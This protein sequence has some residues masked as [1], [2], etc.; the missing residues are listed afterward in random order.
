MYVITGRGTNSENGIAKIRPNV[1]NYLKQNK[2]K[3]E[4]FLKYILYINLIP[5]FR[6]IEPHVGLLRIDLLSYL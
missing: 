2:I 5:I 4:I 1:I 3:Y 6:Y